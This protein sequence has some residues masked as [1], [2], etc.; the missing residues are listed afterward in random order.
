[1]AALGPEVCIQHRDPGAPVRGFLERARWL[2][3]ITGTSGAQLAVNGRLD[4][5]RVIRR[6]ERGVAFLAELRRRLV[7]TPTGPAWQDRDHRGAPN[8]NPDGTINAQTMTQ[9]VNAPHRR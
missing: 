4:V 9:Q 3:A 7:E 2:A 6:L 8:G 1:M 5:Q